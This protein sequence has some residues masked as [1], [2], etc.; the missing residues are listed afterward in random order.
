MAIHQF[1]GVSKRSV[2]GR[3]RLATPIVAIAL[4]LSPALPARAETFSSCWV[5][6]SVHPVFGTERQVTRCRISGGSIIDYASD[7][8]VPSRLYA[9]TGTDISG[10][11]WYYT[12]AV[13][14]YVILTQYA[15]GDADIGFDADPGGLG[16]IVAIGPTLPRCTTE[17]SPASDPT[18]DVYRYV[19]QYIHNPPTPDLNPRP[20]DG[21]TGL[22]TYVG[23]P[24]PDDHTAQ[25]TSGATTL[26]VFI[27]VSAVIID[28]GDES[29]DSYPGTSTAL[30]G[31]PDGFATHIYEQKNEAGAQI[32]V[33]YDW[34]ARW[35]IVGESWDFLVVPNT[36]T[37]ID[38][39]VSEIVSVLSD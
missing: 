5:S 20:G 23:V 38:Y 32:S 13:T 22:A 31:Y 3:L 7:T 8:A 34:T 4:L 11:C 1:V 10:Q 25:L 18:A 24:V 35:R 33:S 12:S 30:A 28:W 16:G 14:Q 29:T 9:Q 17:P 6:T 39:P 36:T 21:V 15:N 26:D 37:T 27:E 19:T 2:G